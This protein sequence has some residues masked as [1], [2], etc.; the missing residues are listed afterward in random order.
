MIFN[1]SEYIKPNNAGRK[2]FNWS[3]LALLKDKVLWDDLLRKNNLV[4]NLEN[5]DIFGHDGIIWIGFISLYRKYF[6]NL[7]TQIILP[8]NEKHIAFIKYIGFDELKDRLGIYFINEY[9]LDL[10]EKE[11][12]SRDDEPFSPR[13]IQLLGEDGL[14]KSLHYVTK[15]VSNYL[16]NTFNVPET[17][18]EFYKCVQPFTETIREFILNISMHSGY[19]GKKGIGLFSYT[20]PPSR[21]SILRFCCNDIGKGFKYTLRYKNHMRGIKNDRQAIIEALLY[22]FF[23]IEEGI[24]GLY[25]TLKYI[26]ERSGKIGIRTG[27]IF[28]K[29]DLSTEHYQRIFDKHYNTPSKIWLNELI[30]FYEYPKIPG[31]HVFVDLMLPKKG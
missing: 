31:S 19:E 8:N 22:R 13:R 26:R 24:E 23:N 17:G 18:E 12:K 1:V 30:Q 5:I 28:S 9:L 14:F 20:P 25:P 29:L 3:T 16:V 7:Y 2:I 15:Y 4:I 21:Y 11:Y 10:T 27:S 6:K